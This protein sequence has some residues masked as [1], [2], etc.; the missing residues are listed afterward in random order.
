MGYKELFRISENLLVFQTKQF[1]AFSHKVRLSTC[2]LIPSLDQFAMALGFKVLSERF[3]ILARCSSLSEVFDR[4]T[5]NCISDFSG[6]IKVDFNS[7]HIWEEGRVE[8]TLCCVTAPTTGVRVIEITEGI[9]PI[10]T[11]STAVIQPGGHGQRCRRGH[12]PYD[13]PVLV[14]NVFT[15]L[16]KAGK[17]GTLATSLQAIAD[18]AAPSSW[19]CPEGPRRCRRTGLE[20]SGETAGARSAQARGADARRADLACRRR[21]RRQ[22]GNP[23]QPG[24]VRLDLAKAYLD[25]GDRDTARTLLD[26]IAAPLGDTETVRSEAARMLQELG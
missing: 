26:E 1:K 3:L 10:R 15:A 12:V 13:K 19:W 22:S 6:G 7:Q 25:M 23:S 20:P 11:I 24:Q 5:L 4:L 17:M 18:H 21:R 8:T 16:G 14:T 9:R 2:S